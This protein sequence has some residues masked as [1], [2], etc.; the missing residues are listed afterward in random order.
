MF[1]HLN[2]R[3]Y[4]SHTHVT[5][6]DNGQS[7]TALGSPTALAPPRAAALTPQHWLLMRVARQIR[8]AGW[9]TWSFNRVLGWMYNRVLGRAPGP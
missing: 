3:G 1:H 6:M 5:C 8:T 9:T 4:D 7:G 2:I